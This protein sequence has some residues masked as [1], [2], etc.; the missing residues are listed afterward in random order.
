MTVKVPRPFAA[1]IALAVGATCVSAQTLIQQGHALDANPQV[2][3]A[4]LNYARPGHASGLAN[5]IVTGNVGGGLGFRGYSPI[6]DPSSLFI[7]QYGSVDSGGTLPGLGLF[8]SSNGLPSDAL[9]P[10]NRESVSVALA[11]Q[12]PLVMGRPRTYYSPSST[13]ANTG[14]I[15]AGLNQPGSSQLISPYSPARPD[16]R[17]NLTNPLTGADAAGGSL[18][19]NPSRL[20]RID[21][22]RPITGQVNERLL[23]S[24]LFGAVREVS[25]AD[26]AAEA[27][28]GTGGGPVDLRVRTAL[29]G[30]RSEA[31][32]L[33]R[34]VPA[35]QDDGV[36]AEPGRAPGLEGRP[37]GLRSD[38]GE[39][40]A[41]VWAPGTGS[42]LGSPDVYAG[43]RRATGS[44]ARP[45]PARPQPGM[46]DAAVA[47]TPSPGGGRPGEAATGLP[48]QAGQSLP[49][50]SGEI[51]IGPVRTFVGTEASAL[52]R[53]LAEAE[54]LLNEGQYYRAADMYEIA[55]SIDPR[56]P[57]PMLGRS[58][59]LLAAGDYL[60]SANNLFQAMRLF[61]RLALF[62]I[63]LKAFVADVRVLDR[64]RADLENR[65]GR[66]DDF[67]LRFLL[68]FAAYSSGL[69]EVG[70]ADLERAAAAAPPEMEAARRFVELLK[71]QQYPASLPATERP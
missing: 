25:V 14:A 53:Y 2:G 57:L 27:R 46:P 40:S 8:T 66:F 5:R 51:P 16:Q 56:N 45:L 64:R 32:V 41:D 55:R 21:N 19:A 9:T 39:E 59:A 6:R 31:G 61:D 37:P 47:G 10:F 11:R 22:G 34:Q 65:L 63:D 23:G 3:S 30:G 58:M 43:M 69:E 33:R 4:G 29:P 49:T 13:V 35:Q 60:T 20:I 7:R 70:L 67:R 12:N 38:S 52:N 15:I 28:Q 50:P 48:G 36:L 44:L 71:R 24:S 1:A 17:Q 68:G 18:L 54:R 26:L 62:H 42:L